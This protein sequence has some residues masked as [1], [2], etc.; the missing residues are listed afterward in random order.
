LLKKILSDE[1]IEFL[2]TSVSVDRSFLSVE[3]ISRAV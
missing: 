1:C 2:L 3:A